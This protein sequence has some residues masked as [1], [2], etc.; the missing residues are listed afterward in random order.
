MIQIREET[1]RDI[2]A[3]EAT[4]R[5]LLRTRALPEDLRAPAR[6]AA[7]GARACAR[8]R[9]GRRAVVGTVRLWHVSAGPGRPALLLGPLAVDLVPGSSLGLGRS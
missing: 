5:C 3:R 1:L 6:R 7:A 4:A 8:R 9:A 2:D